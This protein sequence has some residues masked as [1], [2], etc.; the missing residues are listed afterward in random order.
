MPNKGLA[1]RTQLLMRA[2]PHSLQVPL[3][4]TPQCMKSFLGDWW[5]RFSGV[6][7]P[8]RGRCSRGPCRTRPAG[9]ASCA[10]RGGRRPRPCPSPPRP[11]PEPPARARQ[12]ARE[13]RLVCCQGCLTRAQRLLWAAAAAVA[14]A[15]AARACARRCAPGRDPCEGTW[16]P[17]QP[18]ACSARMGSLWAPY[19]GTQLRWRAQPWAPRPQRVSPGGPAAQRRRRSQAAP[20]GRATARVT[21]SA[22]CWRRCSHRRT[23]LR[24]S[25]QHEELARRMP[26]KRETRIVHVG[27]GAAAGDDAVPAEETTRSG[28]AAGDVAVPA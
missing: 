23:G 21:V 25:T 17:P 12:C 8:Q 10:T 7:S 15:G 19:L 11:C 9:T 13:G 2:A 28:A 18:A 16:P 3:T 27:N 22:C 5:F 24:R 4:S 6:P 26:R 1:Q 14:A 20:S